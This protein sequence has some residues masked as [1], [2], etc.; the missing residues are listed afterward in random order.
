M[1]PSPAARCNGRG[2]GAGRSGQRGRR[3][4]RRPA[5]ASPMEGR[6][7]DVLHW[8]PGSTRCRCCPDSE[9]DDDVT[10]ARTVRRGHRPSFTALAPPPAAAGRRSRRRPSPARPANRGARRG[11]PRRPPG[12]WLSC[13][14]TPGR[15]ARRTATRRTSTPSTSSTTG[16]TRPS[17]SGLAGDQLPG[18]QETPIAGGTARRPALRPHS[19]PEA[20]GVRHQ[21]RR[22]RRSTSYISRDKNFKLD[23]WPPRA[24]DV[25]KIIDSK[26]FGIPIRGQVSW[27]F[28]YWNKDLLQTSRHPRADAE[29]DA[30]RLDRPTP[31][32]CS[33][34]ATP[35]S[36]PSS[37]PGGSFERVTAEVRRFGGEFFEVPAGAGK[38]L[39]AGRGPGLQAIRW[40]YDNIQGRPLRPARLGAGG[41]RPGQERLHLRS[42][43]R[44]AGHR[45]QQRQ[46]RLRVDLRHRPQGADRAAGRASSPSTCSRS[47]TDQETRTAPGSCSSG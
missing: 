31:A 38:T 8:R 21:G 26:V 10:K 13:A 37:T 6:P 22:R 32:S 14:P 42:P 1:M 5:L 15:T 35:T 45:G 2:A 39:H 7:A 43:G 36:S 25:M 3:L 34:R 47:G 16:S 20:P 40:F 23:D 33:S 41:V 19:Q 18:K 28:L 17:T 46:G 12:R 30:R 44:P 9:R 4:T 29:L 11:A 24:Q 27:L